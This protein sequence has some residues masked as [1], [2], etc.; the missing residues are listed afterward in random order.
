ME[1]EPLDELTDAFSILMQDST[2]ESVTV[3]PGGCGEPLLYMGFQ[4][5]NDIGLSCDDQMDN[6]SQ[7][8]HVMYNMQITEDGCEYTSRM[9]A[10]GMEL[11]CVYVQE[12]MIPEQEQEN[13]VEMCSRHVQARYGEMRPKNV[14]CI[15]QQV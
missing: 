2:G 5:M 15:K 12:R 1:I 14:H 3:S 4:F 6:Q 7:V 8:H 9:T 10:K 13:F 11:L